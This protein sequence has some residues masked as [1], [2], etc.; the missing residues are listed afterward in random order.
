MSKLQRIAKDVRDGWIPFLR[1]LANN[2][3]IQFIIRPNEHPRTDGKKVYLPT[4]PADLTRDDL[5]LFKR[6]GFHEV[7]HCMHS[8]VEFFREFSMQH[9]AFAGMLLNA[10]DDVFME[11]AQ[12]LS[13]RRSERYFREGAAIMFDRGMFR[14]GSQ[15]PQEAFASYTLCFLRSRR[16]SE[17]LP[18]VE[19]IRENFNAHFGEHAEQVRENLETILLAEFPSVRSTE[20]A[21]DLTLR[22][23]EMLKQQRDQQDDQPQDEPE[24]EESEGND[25]DDQDAQSEPKGNEKGDEDSDQNQG[26]GQTQNQDDDQEPDDGSNGN[27]GSDD[28]NDE[29]GSDAP[30]NGQGNTES[31]EAVADDKSGDDQGQ[32]QSGVDLS[33]LIEQMLSGNGGDDSEV[34][35][36][37]KMLQQLAQSIQNGTNPDYENAAPVPAFEVEP[38]DV[39]FQPSLGAGQVKNMVEGML[40]CP[41]NKEHARVLGDALDRKVG[42]LATKLQAFLLNREE[43]DV[44]STRRGTLGQSHLYRAGMGDSRIFERKEET[45]LPT[46]AVSVLGDLSSSTQFVDPAILMAKAK[47]KA[48][49]LKA[50]KVIDEK[51]YEV[52]TVAKSIQQILLVLEKV[53]HRIDTPREF[54]GFAPKTGHLNTVV[55][56]FGDSHLTAMDRI[57]GLDSITG[58]N[59]TPI[60][61]AVFQAAQRLASHPA[62]RKLMFVLTDGAPSSVDLAVQ[63]TAAAVKAGIKV[64][65]LLIG[66]HVRKDWLEE[67]GIP[68]AEAKTADDVGP[69]LLEQAKQLLM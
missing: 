54:L 33:E 35:D 66:E 25:E 31:N 8:N 2:S 43:A 3:K 28:D 6:W 18:P 5:T 19:V 4:L 14:D 37:E 17:Y 15:S 57:G 11:Y 61:E 26:D 41:S 44:Y 22:L 56:T 38:G 58:G 21:G 59:H 48:E 50:G 49:A 64:V 68:F 32:G 20:D 39:E 67:Q 62:Q 34:L 65:Y 7:G 10:I 27:Q 63:Q 55:R 30:A 69:V 46:A 23:I 53:F 1:V 24:D 52:L 45:E 60:G 42:A 12:T 36:M 13:S 40:V 16:W 47:A 51:D 29:D 9:G